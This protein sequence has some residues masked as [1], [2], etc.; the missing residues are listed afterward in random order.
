[1]ADVSSESP[2][3]PS[4][5]IF[6]VLRSPQQLVTQKFQQ[7]KE[8][9]K[10]EKKLKMMAGRRFPHSN[11]NLHEVR[12]AHRNFLDHDDVDRVAAQGVQFIHLGNFPSPFRQFSW[13]CAAQAAQVNVVSRICSRPTVCIC[14]YSSV[15]KVVTCMNERAAGELN[16]TLMNRSS[17]AGSPLAALSSSVP[18]I[19]L[20]TLALLSSQR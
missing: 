17:R 9:N 6:W 14:V 20:R 3:M 13:D 5:E 19:T 1:M 2:D 7:L 18:H 8:S 10:K 16:R 12:G 11:E 15:T 4:R